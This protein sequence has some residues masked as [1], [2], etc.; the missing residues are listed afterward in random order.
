MWG[1]YR[2]VASDCQRIGVKS[3]RLCYSVA[4]F[5]RWRQTV[6]T[7]SFIAAHDMSAVG[8]WIIVSF[9]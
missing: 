4:S 2:G 1:R 6:C 8:W 3:S 5:I 9:G 7:Q